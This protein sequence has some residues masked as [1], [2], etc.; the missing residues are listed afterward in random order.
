MK[1]VAAYSL[2]FA[3]SAATK[4]PKAVDAASKQARPSK[5][6]F[7]RAPEVVSKKTRQEFAFN[8]FWPMPIAQVHMLTTWTQH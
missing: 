7:H 4:A 2:A 1:N 8:D 3:R 5:P 6:W